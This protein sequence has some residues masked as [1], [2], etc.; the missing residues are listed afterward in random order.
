VALPPPENEPDGLLSEQDE[1][2][3]P[4]TCRSRMQNSI[5]ELTGTKSAPGK[6]PAFHSSFQFSAFW[7][8][9]F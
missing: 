1:K 8:F 6:S 5:C 7:F 4:P 3:D 9:S 2:V